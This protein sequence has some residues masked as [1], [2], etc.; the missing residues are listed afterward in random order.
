MKRRTFDEKTVL[1]KLEELGKWVAKQVLDEEE[2]KLIIPVRTLSNTIWD[3]VKK[4]LLL[5]SRKSERNFF[6]LN[7]AKKFMQTML[8]LSIIVQAR[9]E[10]DYPTI[11]DLYYFG[12]HTLEYYDHLKRKRRENTWDDQRESNAVL[13][14]IEVMTG[15]LREHMGIMHDAKGKMVGKIIVRSSGDTIDC[16]RMGDGAYAIP[17][18]PDALEILELD[19]DYVLVVEKDAIFNRLN[20][21]RFWETNRC[22]LITGKGQPDRSTRRMVRRLWEEHNL[23][24]YVLTDSIPEDEIVIVRNPLDNVVKIAPIGEILGHYFTGKEKERIILPLEVPSWNPNTG[25][26]E[27]RLIGYAYRHK[28]KEKIL[29]IYTDQRGIIRTTKA[30]SLFVFRKGKVLVVPAKEIKVGDYIIVANRIPQVGNNLQKIYLAEAIHY[31]LSPDERV[32]FKLEKNNCLAGINDIPLDKL[33]EYKW[34]VDENGR[35]LPNEIIINEE[36]SWLLGLITANGV[37]H[38]DKCISIVLKD[39]RKEVLERAKKL[40]VKK[41]NITCIQVDEREKKTS[42]L[43][44]SKGF[45]VLLSWMGLNKKIEERRI[46]EVI[47]NSPSNVILAYIEGLIEDNMNEDGN[48]MYTIRNNVLAKQVFNLLLTLGLPVT[49][50]LDKGRCIIEFSKKTLG[51]SSNTSRYF[52]AKKVAQYL[53][54]KAL[55]LSSTGK[56]TVLVHKIKETA[57][58]CTLFKDHGGLGDVS[59]VRVENIE[60]EDYDGYVYDFAVPGNESFVGG[61]GIVYHNSDPYGFYIYSVYKSGSISLSYESERLA[62]PGACFIG[63]APSDIKKYKLPPQA[64]IKA[65]DTDIKR[66]KELLRYPWFKSKAWKRELKLFLKTQKKVE[67]E[68][69]STHGFKFLSQKYLPDKLEHKEWID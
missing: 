51:V 67:I 31:T 45:Y 28:I 6:D 12:K 17:P 10:G 2:P 16:S 20:K 48:I 23:P 3:P 9:R 49:L 13:Q 65:K 40:L 42:L 34:V 33:R 22:I 68:G 60:E 43:I 44:E 56:G 55:S 36:V 14:D 66:A 58:P 4:M 29:K 52:E 18:N 15:L 39:P 57:F 7:E 8:M 5:G 11:R 69:L 24:V 63:V 54:A 64:I 35:R 61:F 27:W 38:Q 26:I 41:F 53:S 21:E 59:A 32:S 1:E 25:N 46:P 47:V 62:T 19:A 37:F 30:H 50:T